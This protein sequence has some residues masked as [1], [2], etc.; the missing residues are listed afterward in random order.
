MT[1][2]EP[3]T[4]GGHES[5]GEVQREETVSVRVPL[6]VKTE[7]QQLAYER[8]EPGNR[9]SMSELVCEA[10]EEHYGI[11]MEVSTEK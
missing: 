1:A 4:R 7:L 6:R 8:T 5:D 9:V 2:S 10:I 3:D 11:E